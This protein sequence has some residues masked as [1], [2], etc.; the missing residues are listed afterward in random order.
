VT[1]PHNFSERIARVRERIDTACERAEREP[2][3]VQL[4][5]VSKRHPAERVRE[6]IA[7]GLNVFGEG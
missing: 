2:S 6:A 5:A 3:S 7:A 1:E 4:V